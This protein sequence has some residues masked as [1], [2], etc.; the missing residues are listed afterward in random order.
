MIEGLAA[1]ALTLATKY[2]QTSS[3]VPKSSFLDIH[4]SLGAPT[5]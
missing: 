5:A 2:H 3:E 1:L 4:P